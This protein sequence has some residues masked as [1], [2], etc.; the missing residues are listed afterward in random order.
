MTGLWKYYYESG[1][2]KEEV[3]FANNLE[4]G[5]YKKYHENGTLA[6]EGEY[7]AEI[8]NGLW[9]YYHANGAEQEQVTYV[10]G[11]EE[12]WVYVLSETGDTV[13][14]INY[15]EGRPLSFKEKPQMQQ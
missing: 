7:K 6:A 4:N 9:K 8:E 1:Q 14:W 15:K 12:G 3:N 2:L 5:L 10:N 13:K 11:K